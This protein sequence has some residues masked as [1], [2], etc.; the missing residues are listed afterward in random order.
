MSFH[1]A[2]LRLLHRPPIS[3]P[4]ALARLKEC[5]QAL[6]IQFPTA[7]REWYALHDP[8][9]PLSHNDQPISLENLAM[10][11]W[12]KPLEN[13]YL[14]FMDENQSVCQSWRAVVF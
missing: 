8:I 12:D 5:E 7:V 9:G 4:T 3:S 11:P 6:N 10:P 2:T 13:G 14:V 1:E